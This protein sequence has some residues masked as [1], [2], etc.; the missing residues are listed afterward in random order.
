MAITVNNVQTNINSSFSYTPSSVTDSVLIAICSSENFPAGGPITGIS[1]GA[2]GMT[3]AINVTNTT[4][5]PDQELAI[6][7]LI[8][9]GTSTETM[10]V[11]GPT[12]RIGW[13]VLT[14]GGAAQSSPVDGTASVVSNS[15]V[16]A[17]DD[18]VTTAEDNSIIIAAVTGNSNGTS[19][20]AQGTQ[21]LQSSINPSSSSLGSSTQ[22][23][24]TAGLENQG[25]DFSEA[26]GANAM[27][28]A[29]FKEAGGAPAAA[30][31]PI[32]IVTT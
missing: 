15:S 16:S 24:A 3:E 30:A 10:T 2:T 32:V 29:A 26:N 17:L 19:Y 13:T 8:N 6:F 21:T 9:P 23:L 14:L 27:V 25:F 12:A 31:Q 7:Y 20:T 4:P 11:T 28:I 22:I 1:Y 5:S 18:D